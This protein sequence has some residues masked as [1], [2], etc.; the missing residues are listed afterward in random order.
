[1]VLMEKAGFAQFIEGYR[2]SRV[3]GDIAAAVVR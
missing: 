2:A 3:S 1:L